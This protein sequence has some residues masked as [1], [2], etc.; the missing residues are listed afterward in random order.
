MT[1]LNLSSFNSGFTGL[2]TNLPPVW[3]VSK[4]RQHYIYSYLFYLYAFVLVIYLYTIVNIFV[5]VNVFVYEL[6][7]V[8]INASFVFVFD[9]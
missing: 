5:Y 1:V 6:V 4:I 2:D 7:F 3:F 9:A 8:L